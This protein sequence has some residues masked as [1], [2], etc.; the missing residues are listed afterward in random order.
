M[1]WIAGI[2]SESQYQELLATMEVLIED[3]SAHQSV[4]DLMFPV[5]EMY[6]SESQ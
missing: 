6:E 3:Y 1:P 4:I 2:T 5:I